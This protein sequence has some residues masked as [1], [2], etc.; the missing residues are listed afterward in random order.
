M[1]A[2][3]AP[4]ARAKREAARSRSAEEASSSGEAS[5]DASDEEARGGDVAE[6]SERAPGAKVAD[7][8]RGGSGSG[9]GAS[10]AAPA[11]SEPAAPDARGR[12]PRRTPTPR[13]G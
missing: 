4:S 12:A 2:L 5:F 6:C 3:T 9:G 8:A 10:R 7:D 11:S 1:A 13:G